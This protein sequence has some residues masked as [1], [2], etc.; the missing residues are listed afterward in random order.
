MGGR[1]V[2]E[3]AAGKDRREGCARVCCRKRWEGG[4]ERVCLK[5]KDER[6]GCARVCYRKRQEGGC[7]RV[8]CRKRQEGGFARV[9]SGK[10]G[11]ESVKECAQEKTGGVQECALALSNLS[12]SL[13]LTL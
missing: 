12:V 2:Q 5:G 6:E 10:D 4:C 9:C 11:R 7:A 3:C 8:Y 13:P 1:G